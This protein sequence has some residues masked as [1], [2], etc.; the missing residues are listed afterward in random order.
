MYNAHK[1]VQSMPILAIFE[2]PK[3][4][5]NWLEEKYL[6]KLD[7]GE[8]KSSFGNKK[9]LLLTIISI[10]ESWLN[11]KSSPGINILFSSKVET[12]IVASTR[13]R[14]RGGPPLEKILDPPLASPTHG[15]GSR[16][17]L[18]LYTKSERQI[19]SNYLK[20]ILKRT[21]TY[22]TTFEQNEQKLQKYEC[23]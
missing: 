10:A 16:N 15:V 21:T 19:S 6:F 9:I 12:T 7:F 5:K 3:L 11:E 14:F 1:L 2:L 17:D 23:L 4:C 18:F 22:F 13:D 8:S 20:C